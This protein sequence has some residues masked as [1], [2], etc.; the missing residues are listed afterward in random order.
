MPNPNPNP[1]RNPNPDPDPDPDPYPNPNPNP[2]QVES[3]LLLAARGTAGA[4]PVVQLLAAE[5]FTDYRALGNAAT[6]TARA[7]VCLGRSL[8]P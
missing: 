8:H 5:G 7:S 3:P 4:A 2:N 1:N 6:H